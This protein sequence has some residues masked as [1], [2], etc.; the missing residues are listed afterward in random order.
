M[1]IVLLKDFFHLGKFGD[2]LEVA[3]GYARNYLI[4]QK[5]AVVATA[6]S[7]EY[8]ASKK[9]E[10]VELNA[11]LK[12]EAQKTLDE[13]VNY[14]LPAFIR[15][16]ADDNK[17]F[18][19]VTKRDIAA[20]LSADFASIKVENILLINPLKNLGVYAVHLLLHPELARHELKVIIAR[21][22]EEAATLNLQINDNLSSE[23]K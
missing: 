6:E 18:G 8:I 9:Q 1:Q 16:S 13:L 7:K 17:L 15:Q 2:V 21:S 11:T 14:R 12:A 19:S 3:P 22:E 10:L 23:N 20:L 5:I 4:P